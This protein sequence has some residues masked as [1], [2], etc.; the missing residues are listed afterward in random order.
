MRCEPVAVARRTSTSVAAPPGG[1]GQG[2]PLWTCESLSARM[3]EPAL[4]LT[5]TALFPH[6]WRTDGTSH[7]KKLSALAYHSVS[8]GYKRPSGRPQH[9][10]PGE[11]N[12]IDQKTAFLFGANEWS[13]LLERVA[14][15]L[16]ASNET[17][18]VLNGQLRAGADEPIVRELTQFLSRSGRR[19]DVI[20]APRAS[21]SGWI[22]SFGRGWTSIDLRGRGDRLTHAKMPGR[23][24]LVA[25]RRSSVS[26]LTRFDPNRPAIAIGVWAQFAHPF[27]RFGAAIS[28]QGDGLTAELA[29]AAPPAWYFASASWQ[30]KPMALLAD[31]MIAA[32]LLGLAIGQIQADPDREPA[33]PW[34]HPLV[35]RAT[36]L[37]LGVRTPAEIE[38]QT[39]MAG[40]EPESS[41]RLRVVRSDGRGAH[42][43]RDR[44]KIG[45]GWPPL[46]IP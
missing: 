23:L 16:P 22:G 8:G 14:R 19:V 34:E 6:D 40:R 36:E 37:D 28:G 13:E 17:L 20:A 33:G 42:R 31:D 25:I 29:L 9:R 5:A 27:Q 18:L 24:S 41:G 1:P 3:S 30:G 12:L 44:A 15:A 43:H 7:Q 46:A 21:P 10:R 11:T 39:D 4:P 38:F 26:D 2:L 35:Q 45:F 32:E